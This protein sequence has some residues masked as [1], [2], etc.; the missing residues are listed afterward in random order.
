MDITF[1]FN[2]TYTSTIENFEFGDLDSE[3]I[4]YIFKDGRVFSHF[5]EP[6]LAKQFHLKHIEGCKDHDFTDINNPKIQYDQKTFTKG[7]CKFYP[8]NMIGTGRTFNQEKFE[9]KA[10]KLI[11]IIVS[12]VDFPEI[13]I[14]FIRGSELILKYPKG[15]IKS[16]DFIEF[17]N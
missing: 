11:Y 10:N 8:S 14:K 9:E 3:K 15:E 17:F 1:E 16:K 2:K 5:I 4:K 13:K 6:W 7:G 12:N